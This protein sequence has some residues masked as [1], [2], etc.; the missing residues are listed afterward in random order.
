M[1]IEKEIRE[2]VSQYGD[3]LYRVCM[4]ILCNE[5]DVQDAVQD[6]F[7]RYL[8]K[9]PEFRDEEHKKA[10]LIRVATNICRDMIRFRIR[11]PGVSIDEVENT[12]A[13][14]EQKRIFRELLELPVRQKTVLYLHYVEGYQI[15]EIADIL[16]IT[17][18][19]VKLRLMRGRK[20]MRGVLGM[21]GGI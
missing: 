4:V 5:Q 17:Q 2:A 11:H 9:K 8:E 19:A 18:S 13:A 14:P 20:Q 10:W 12:L 7:C 1:D 16:G 3:T 15:R 6:T 21:E